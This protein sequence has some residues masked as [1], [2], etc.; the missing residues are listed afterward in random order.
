MIILTTS[1]IGDNWILNEVSKKQRAL[2]ENLGVNIPTTADFK[3]L[4]TKS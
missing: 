2:F 4:V 1:K 3:T